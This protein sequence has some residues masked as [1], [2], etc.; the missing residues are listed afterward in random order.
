MKKTKWLSKSTKFM[1]LM[2]K[3]KK[4][5]SED[6]SDSDK[7]NS[8]SDSSKSSKSSKSGSDSDSSKSSSE[9]EEDEEDEVPKFDKKLSNPKNFEVK[10]GKQIKYIQSKSWG[11]NFL[12]KPRD[13]YSFK[14]ISS[15]SGYIMFGYSPKENFNF[16]DSVH[17]SVGFYFYM[18]NGYQYSQNNGCTRSTISN[19]QHGYSSGIVYSIKFDK[20]KRIISFYKDKVCLGNYYENIDKKLKLYP[21]VSFNNNGDAIE[22]IKN[23]K[24]KK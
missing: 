7:S 8:D 23:P 20:K 1:N 19:Y 11:G 18:C 22:L 13:V 3:K 2:I 9:S 4:E 17:N 12:L 14:V 10:K 5:S 6:D 15:Q 24:L 21:A 16:N